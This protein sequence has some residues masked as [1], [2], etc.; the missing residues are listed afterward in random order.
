MTMGLFSDVG[1]DYDNNDDSYDNMIVRRIK[2]MDIM[3]MIMLM[4]IIVLL[5][6]VLTL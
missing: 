4:M 2:M 1:E 5:L 6:C 3:I